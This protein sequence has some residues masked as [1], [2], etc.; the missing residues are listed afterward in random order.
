MNFSIQ[1]KF[2]AM[3][4]LFTNVRSFLVHKVKETMNY[5]EF[6]LLTIKNNEE[7]L[8][9][10]FEEINAKLRDKDDTLNLMK[11]THYINLTNQVDKLSKEQICFGKIKAEMNLVTREIKVIVET[12]K[13][14]KTFTYDESMYMDDL[15]NY[16]DVINKIAL[17]QGK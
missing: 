17:N 6:D 9:Q 10:L 5:K 3:E 1:E 16:M 12:E 15:S 11:D 4:V 2:N 13:E 14:N 7:E 8:H